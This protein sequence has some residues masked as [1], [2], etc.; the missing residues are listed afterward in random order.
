LNG[1][2]DSSANPFSLKLTISIFRL[3]FLPYLIQSAFTAKESS[4]SVAPNPLFYGLNE[5]DLPK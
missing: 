4:P 2:E 5:N 3:F 1:Y